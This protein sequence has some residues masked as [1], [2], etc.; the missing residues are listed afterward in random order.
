MSTMDTKRT[1]LS[2][3]VNF[4]IIVCVVVAVGA[5]VAYFGSDVHRTRMNAAATQFSEWTPENIAKDPENYLNFCESE[6]QKALL[7]LKASEISVAQNEAGLN[8]MLADAKGKITLGEKALAELKA[9]Y[10]ETEA[11]AAWPITWNGRSFDRDAARLQIVRLNKEVESKHGVQYKVEMGLKKLDAQKNKIMEARATT[12]QQISEIKTGR[13]TL[14]VE[15][16][17]Q[18]LAG[19]LASIGGALQATIGSVTQDTG[20]FNIDQL[21]DQA[22]G[23]VDDAEFDAIMGK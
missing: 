1:G 7:T 13:E 14:K 16:L 6:A 19:Q 5:L 20:T 10:T 17:T 4:I 21:A 3:V 11:A 18:E 23:T 2:S 8:S 12:E 15:K 22:V 9:K